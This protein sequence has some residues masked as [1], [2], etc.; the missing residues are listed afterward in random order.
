MSKSTH[1]LNQQ[2]ERVFAGGPAEVS[3]R[4]ERRAQRHS[5]LSMSAAPLEVVT[6]N[7]S[8]APASPSCTPTESVDIFCGYS[9]HS[10]P[11]SGKG[12]AKSGCG[13]MRALLAWRG[14]PRAG[15]WS[16]SAGRPSNPRPAPTRRKNERCKFRLGRYRWHHCGIMRGQEG[17]PV[18]LRAGMPSRSL[19]SKNQRLQARRGRHVCKAT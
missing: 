10:F 6:T 15:F 2:I 13:T 1:N 9:I 11:T 7:T 14:H 3:G 5:L 4:A 17:L 18:K 16:R 12:L 8:Q 19:G